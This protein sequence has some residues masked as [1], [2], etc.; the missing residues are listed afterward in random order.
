MC[1][2]KK[3]KKA[4]V[5]CV[6]PLNVT[7]HSIQ[8][9]QLISHSMSIKCFSFSGRE[10]YKTHFFLGRNQKTVGDTKLL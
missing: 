10:M 2:K 8:Q 5:V 1:K 7:S 9:F 3:R 4:A 6:W